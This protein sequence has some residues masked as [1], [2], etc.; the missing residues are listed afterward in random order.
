ME[1]FVFEEISF[2]E[3]NQINAGGLLELGYAL[4]GTFLIAGAPIV[5]TLPGAG[6]IGG[7]AMIGQGVTLL[8]KLQK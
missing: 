2:D 5:A 7:L 4:G 1:N 3:L 8:G 6:V